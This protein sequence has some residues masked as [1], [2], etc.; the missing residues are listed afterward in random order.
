[1]GRGLHFYRRDPSRMS[2]LLAPLQRWYP[3]RLTTQMIGLLLGAL[4]IA[5][6]ANFL[7]FM[8]ERRAAI[9]L[10]ERTQILERTVSLVQLIENSSPSSHGKTVQAA[11]SRKLYFWFAET[12]PIPGNIPQTDNDLMSRLQELLGDHEIRELRILTHEQQKSLLKGEKAA[13]LS[14]GAEVSSFRNRLDQQLASLPLSEVDP[15]GLLI[16]AH[17]TDGRWLSAGLGINPPLSRWAL[18]TFFSM[19]FAAGSICVIVVFMV[20]RITRPLLRLAEAAEL[21]GRGET[22]TPVSED[23]PVD[24][25]QTIHAFNRMYDR[26]QRFVQDRTRM[27]AAISHDLRTP[28]TSLR[29]QAELIT[30]EEAK[31]KILK[32]LEEMQRITEATLAFARDEASTEPSRSVDLAALIDSL[33]QDLADLGMDVSCETTDKTP[34]TCRPMSLKRALRN[35]IENAVTYGYRARVEL[36]QAEGEFH[37]FIRDDGPGIPDQDAERVFQPFVRLEESRSHD[38]GGIGLGMAIA[39]SIAR[40]HG[41]D[42]TLTKEEPQTF[43]VTV[44]LP[45][46]PSATDQSPRHAQAS[47]HPALTRMML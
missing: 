27:L 3:Q 17:L 29:L 26:L 35:L 31:E 11:S 36:R 43:C 9:R 45:K 47:G 46:S 20:K 24:I 15:P 21:V 41:G 42:I 39:R 2:R 6:V 19:V 4:V 18:P 13:P 1:M 22:I 8:D 25:Q 38:T 5:Q 44:H 30:D 12:S 16:S 40:Q 34:Y 32:T 14:T 37:I 23:G 7:I 33:C 10:V 28:I